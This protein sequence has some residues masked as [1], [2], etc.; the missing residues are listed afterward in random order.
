M[1]KT[2]FIGLLGVML[3]LFASGCTVDTGNQTYNGNGISFQYPTNWEQLSP[4]KIS[5]STSGSAEIIASVV[6]PNS[7]QNNNYQTLVFVQRASTTVSMAEAMAANRAAIESAGG[8]IISQKD[9]TV[10]GIAATELIYTISTP[11][12]VAKKERMVTMDKNNNLYYIICSTPADGFDAQQS[13][14]DQIIQSF[15]IQ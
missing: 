12:G 1:K 3:V 7:I 2:I 11:S 5:A 6:D 8:Q 15:Q 4:D 14:F 13:N 10:N 9:L